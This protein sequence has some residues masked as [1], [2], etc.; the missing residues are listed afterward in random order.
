[1]GLVVKMVDSLE[2]LVVRNDVCNVDLPRV[3]NLTVIFTK[4]A[5][6]T[7]VDFVSFCI[8]VMVMVKVV[9]GFKSLVVKYVVCE[10][11]T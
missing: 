5:E 1:M 10:F 7:S 4:G 3:S 6:L 9:D 8:D 2:N 11:Q